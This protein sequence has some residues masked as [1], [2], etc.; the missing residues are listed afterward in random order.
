MTQAKPLSP[1]VV[2]VVE[3]EPI[4]RM[5]AMDLVEEAGFEALEAADADEAIAKLETRPDIRILF[6]D[7]QMPGSMDGLKLARA[8]RDRWPPIRIILTSGNRREA[9]L[10]LGPGQVFFAKPYDIRKVA[11]MLHRLAH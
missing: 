7:I 9:D 10:D 6:T 4:L 5:M 1:H 8:V 3:D 11:Q 2:L